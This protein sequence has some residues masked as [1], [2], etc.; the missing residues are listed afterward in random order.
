MGAGS[1]AEEEP[2][3]PFGGLTVR[4]PGTPEEPS[5]TATGASEGIEAARER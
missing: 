4:L 3:E 2:W 1:K 5:A